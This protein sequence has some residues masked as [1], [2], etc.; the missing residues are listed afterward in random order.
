MDERGVDS[1]Y[2]LD[3]CFDRDFRRAVK[4]G[5]GVNFISEVVQTVSRSSEAA[6]VPD[7][8]TGSC[9]W[10]TCD[11][12][13]R[14]GGYLRIGA[15]SDDAGGGCGFGEAVSQNGQSV[16]SR[17]IDVTLEIRPPNSRLKLTVHG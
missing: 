11:R 6:S 2:R 4:V 3:R 1:G 17:E 16:S 15:P 5:V 9:V 8:S 10:D 7:R 13:P 14:Q 12:G